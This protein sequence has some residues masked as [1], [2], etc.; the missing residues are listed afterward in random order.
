MALSG[1]RSTPPACVGMPLRDARNIG[2]CVS[3]RSG[4]CGMPDSV[5]MRS[6][7]AALIIVRVMGGCRVRQCYACGDDIDASGTA[8]PNH[9]GV[10]NLSYMCSLARLQDE[11]SSCRASCQTRQICVVA[12]EGCTGTNSWPASTRP[13]I[14][15]GLACTKNQRECSELSKHHSSFRKTVLKC[16]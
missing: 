2:A 12:R 13:S 9:H 10:D 1:A 16:A 8:R 6:C 4:K 15:Q 5:L 11:I 14:K 7:A 3:T